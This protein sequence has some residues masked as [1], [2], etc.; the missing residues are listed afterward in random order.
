MIPTVCPDRFTKTTTTHEWN[1]I[2]TLSSVS[3]TGMMT[4]YPPSP[5]REAVAPQI[6]L[7]CHSWKCDTPKIWSNILWKNS[8]RRPHR[9]TVDKKNV[10]FRRTKTYPRTREIYPLIFLL[11]SN[12]GLEIYRGRTY[13]LRPLAE[14]M[15]RHVPPVPGGRCAHWQW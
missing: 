10:L 7:T 11:F 15:V 2:F 13:S 1:N 9:A 3:C 6:M 12:M 4:R 8:R 14:K 5:P